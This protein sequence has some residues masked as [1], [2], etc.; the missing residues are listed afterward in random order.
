MTQEGCIITLLLQESHLNSNN[1][2][3]RFV[4][5]T[6]VKMGCSNRFSSGKE[7]PPCYPYATYHKRAQRFISE[8]VNSDGLYSYLLS[9]FQMLFYCLSLLISDRVSHPC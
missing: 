6:V 8:G 7:I 3:E 1:I 2:V 9:L 5:C 4:T